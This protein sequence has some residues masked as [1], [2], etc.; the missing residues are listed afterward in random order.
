MQEASTK[1][2][3]SLKKTP[4]AARRDQVP[5]WPSYAGI[6]Q[7]VGTSPTGRV[8]VYVDPTL[9]QQGI[10]N[11]R[12]LL[13]DA[14]RI[15]A[16]N[17]SLFGT[18][19]GATNVIL[20]AM[21]GPDANPATDGTGGAD[22]MACNYT[23]GQNIEVCVSFGNSMRCSALFEAELSECSMGG[24]LCGVSTGEA[25]S[26]WCAAE[27]SNNALADFASAP[28]WAQDGMPNFVDSTD[29]TDTNYDSIGCG[30]AFLSW[31]ISQGNPLNMIAPA[32]VSLGDSGTLAQLYA[33][34]TGDDASNAL[35]NFMAAVQGLPGVTSDDPFGRPVQMALAPA[36]I[37]LAAKVFSSIL[38]DL[39]AGRS[40]QHT[41]ATVRTMLSAPTGRQFKTSAIC[42]TKSH[43]LVL[44]GAG[45]G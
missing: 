34:L 2:H 30:M 14:D 4:V 20:F 43:R 11:A 28:T 44:P 29:P 8:A 18:P 5:Q 10:Q 21:P 9:G 27:I 40:A 6:S 1:T 19:S 39:A 17:N 16:A 42:S 36:T 3:H 45:R 23:D 26:R 32:M 33:S 15:V 12:D 38:A 13:A 24:N 31:L 35:P 37:E 22:H 7:L 25:L 41:V